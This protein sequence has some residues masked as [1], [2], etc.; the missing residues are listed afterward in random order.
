MTD[1]QR[2]ALVLLS[3]LLAYPDEAFYASLDHLA[4]EAGDLA[5][6]PDTAPFASAVANFQAAMTRDGRNAAAE[7]YVATFD[8]ATKASPY[9]AWH[10]Y[11]NDRGQ[12]KALAALNGLYRTAGLEP[13][14]GCMPDYLPRM[15]EFMAIAPEW[16]VAALL[17]GFG[18]EIIGIVNALAE[19]Q[20]IYAPVIEQGLAPLKKEYPELFLPRTGPDAT[21]RPMAKP[22]PE[23]ASP[24]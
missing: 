10:R 1:Q 24:E 16:A 20:S 17:D 14:D 13:M 22:E 21:R 4:R 12:G 2:A 15:L 11:G 5:H 9:L 6:Y 7:N 19:A 23:P 3:K 8:H 18:P